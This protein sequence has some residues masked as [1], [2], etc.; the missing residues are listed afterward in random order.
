MLRVCSR[1]VDL[2]PGLPLLGL[3][4]GRNINVAF[5]PAAVFSRHKHSQLS[6]DAIFASFLCNVI[7]AL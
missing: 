2:R 1:N 5:F 6:F 4:E 7:V 3:S